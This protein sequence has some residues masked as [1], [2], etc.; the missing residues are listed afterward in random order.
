MTR[1]GSQEF[2]DAARDILCVPTEIDERL[3]TGP[4]NG[5]QLDPLAVALEPDHLGARVL[6][7]RRR[8]MHL[9]PLSHKHPCAE[10]KESQRG[11]NES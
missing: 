4:T 5:P 6:H 7:R 10:A 3:T 11:G 9:R 1:E 8:E 2:I